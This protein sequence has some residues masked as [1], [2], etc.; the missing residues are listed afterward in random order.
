M[1]PY[2]AVGDTLVIS[3]YEGEDLAWA[4]GQQSGYQ[5]LDGIRAAENF[6]HVGHA[7]TPAALIGYSGGSI[8]TEWAEEIAAAYAPELDIVGAAAGGVPVDFAHELPYLSGSP[9][10]AGVMPGV[11]VG[12]SRGFNVDL[13]SYLSPYGQQLAQ[14]VSSQCAN[15]FES[16]Y[17]CLTI[18]QL[19]QP[20]YQDFLA[21][22]LVASMI[23]ELTMGSD[24]TPRAPLF[25]GVGNSDGTGD[26]VI[27]ASDVEGL[28]HAYCERGASVQFDEYQH[29]DHLEASAPFESYAFTL[30]QAWLAGL[31]T[32]NGCNGIGTGSP[33]APL[34]NGTSPP[35]PPAGAVSSGNVTSVEPAGSATTFDGTGTLTLQGAGAATLSRFAPGH[36][37]VGPTTFASTGRFLDVAVAPGSRITGAT[38]SICGV[39]AARLLEWWDPAA[40]SGAGAWEPLRPAAHIADNPVAG[41]PSP[42]LIASLSRSSSPSVSQLGTV[43]LGLGRSRRTGG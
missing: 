31:P 10:W 38:V 7:H 15:S 42:C 28:A 34:P 5:T 20:K 30:M 21:N 27:A 1:T 40:N 14:K 32:T 19:V 11:L 9:S 41:G 25:L 17:P 37:P 16:A 26:G 18:Q 33:L 8:A 12:V 6:L 39:G 24:G 36:D 43:V 13:M 4:A 2:L 3:D 22:P 23:N 29:L 35:P